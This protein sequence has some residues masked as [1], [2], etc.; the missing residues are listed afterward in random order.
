MIQWF[1]ETGGVQWIT[2]DAVFGT[3]NP[4]VDGSIPSL[5]TI[6]SNTYVLASGLWLH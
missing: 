4:R 1:G 3:E 2:L 6:K 5:A